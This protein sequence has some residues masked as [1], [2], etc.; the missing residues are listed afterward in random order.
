MPKRQLKAAELKGLF[1]FQDKKHGTVYYDILTGNGYIFTT[2][3]TKYYTLSV[4]FLPIAVIIFY[5]TMQFGLSTVW[6]LVLAIVSYI[7]MQAIYRIKFLYKLPVVKNYKAQ[8]KDTIV[9]NLAKGYSIQRLA[10]LCILSSLLIA[11]TVG[12][13][14]FN[15]LEDL[16]LVGMIIVACIAIGLF[17]VCIL[18]LATKKTQEKQK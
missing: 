16:P 9:T 11:A 7:V 5:F 13:I 18:A 1:I 6:S 14:Y 10:V 4:A 2:S 12:Y 3:D 17:I 8:K 15:D